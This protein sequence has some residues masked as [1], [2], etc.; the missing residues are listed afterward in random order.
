[1]QIGIN[2]GIELIDNVLPLCKPGNC[3][4]SPYQ[5]LGVCP[6]WTDVSDH[7]GFSNLTQQYF[8][9]AEFWNLTQD[10]RIINSESTS[11]FN[12]SSVAPNNRSETDKYPPGP[13][14][15]GQ[16]IAYK[17]AKYPIANVFVVYYNGTTSTEKSPAYSAIEF[18]LE[19]C[20]K[21]FQTTTVNGHTNT[22]L[23][24]E[25]RG[26][27]APHDLD[28]G[29]DDKNPQYKS[30]EPNSRTYTIDINTHYSLQRYLFWFFSGRIFSNGTYTINKD[31]WIWYA[32]ND[33]V[34][35]MFEPF[36]VFQKQ[37]T[38]ETSGQ[39]KNLTGFNQTL[40]NMAISMTN[41]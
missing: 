22:V 10:H 13:L 4:W 2:Q 21:T 34:Q 3:T 23:L 5:T 41:Q 6:S 1:M 19:W 39:G 27:Q 29:N 7:L 36:N 17:D 30:D 20:V 25:R 31:D 24:A 9:R 28:S 11:Y 16:S 12:L 33:V 14:D 26:F 8:S 32:D 18:I 38:S 15:F 35:T 40:Q 37:L